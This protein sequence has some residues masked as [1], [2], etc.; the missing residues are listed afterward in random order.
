MESSSDLPPV[1]VEP[2]DVLDL[3]ECKDVTSKVKLEDNESN[4]IKQELLLSLTSGFPLIKEELKDELD[5]SEYMDVTSKVKIKGYESNFVKKELL[6]STSA[7]SVNKEQLK[8]VMVNIRKMD[9]SETHPP[10]IINLA[11]DD[12][13][14]DEEYDV[15]EV[16]ATPLENS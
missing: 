14:D 1:I 13:K 10:I 12:E 9:A 15:E 4:I 2:K 11:E 16:I 6:P 5:F 7:F 3:A 8:I